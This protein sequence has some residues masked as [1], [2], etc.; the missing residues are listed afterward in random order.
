MVHT[1]VLHL[2]NGLL[3]VPLVNARN[4]L[5]GGLK[6][7]D[8]SL[9]ESLRAGNL[10]SKADVS[11]A[12]TAVRSETQ[13]LIAEARLELLAEITDLLAD[14]GNKGYV[15]KQDMP[16]TVAD[17]Q[18]DFDRNGPVVID[19]YS[20][21]YEVHYDFFEVYHLNSNVARIMFDDPTAFVAVVL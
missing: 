17:L 7:L 11:Q 14:A 9:P 8:A 4:E 20:P 1:D 5:P 6:V 13:R 12:A 10:A 16:V 21:D 3:R 18:H 19:V 15:F 2:R